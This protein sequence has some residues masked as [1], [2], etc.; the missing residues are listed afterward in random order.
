MKNLIKLTILGCVLAITNSTILQAQAFMPG[1]VIFSAGYG[2]PN[3]S[4]SLFKTWENYTDY[5]LSGFGPVHIKGE[6][7]VAEHFGLGLSVNYSNTKVV[8]VDGT[9]NYTL[10]YNPLS[11]NLRGNVHFGSDEKFDPYLGIGVGYGSRKV[12]VQSS[13][14]D[15]T[16]FLGTAFNFFDIPIG[17][18]ATLGARYY[19]T[20]NIGLYVEVGPAKSLVQLGL[21]FKLSSGSGRY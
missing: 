8:F 7:G 3:L 20:D 1:D 19:F 15:V 6:Y 11:V 10:K 17:L 9:Y 13:D 12:Q 14:P 5:T 21:S 18:E 2:T 16:T 4:K